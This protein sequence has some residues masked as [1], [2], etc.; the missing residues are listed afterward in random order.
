MDGKYIILLESKLT[1]FT[2]Q[3]TSHA[4]HYNFLVWKLSKTIYLERDVR[5]QWQME[6]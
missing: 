3:S 5:Y 4:I 6:A 1:N 2:D